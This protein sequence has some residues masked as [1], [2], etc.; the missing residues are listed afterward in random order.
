MSGNM[1][2]SG[3]CS[4][5]CCCCCCCAAFPPPGAI[6]IGGRTPQPGCAVRGSAA[7][8]DDDD[9]V[10]AALPR[11]A[12]VAKEAAAAAAAVEVGALQTDGPWVVVVVAVFVG[13][14]VVS[15]GA[16][17]AVG[18]GDL[19]LR[20]VGGAVVAAVV[21]GVAWALSGLVPSSLSADELLVVDQAGKGQRLRP[22]YWR[23]GPR[24]LQGGGGGTPGRRET[25][26]RARRG[27]LLKE[28]LLGILSRGGILS[29]V[30]MPLISMSRR[31]CCRKARVMTCSLLMAS[32][33]LTRNSRFPMSQLPRASFSW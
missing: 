28:V 1:L 15:E 27:M 25:E 14:F 13:D 22:L 18:P 29:E 26:L 12:S 5:S 2:R 19:R 9:P 20:L 23:G 7:D 4:C 11:C 33:Q 21:V 10:R 16:G 3:I 32:M 24:R 31:A 8:D 17:G 30:V 6:G